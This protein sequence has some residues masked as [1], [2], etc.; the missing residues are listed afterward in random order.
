MTHHPSVMLGKST[1][2]S[3]PVTCLLVMRCSG[4][5]AMQQQKQ[6]GGGSGNASSTFQEGGA[7]LSTLSMTMEVVETMVQVMLEVVAVKKQ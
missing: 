1:T 4:A 6:I 3:T 7:T 2:S 5:S